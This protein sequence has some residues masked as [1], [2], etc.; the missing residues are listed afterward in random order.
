M[1]NQTNQTS[2]N[3]EFQQDA[4][5]RLPSSSLD[6]PSLG[7]VL[8]AISTGGSVNDSIHSPA[9]AHGK[10]TTSA[11]GDG[12]DRAVDVNVSSGQTPEV[13]PKT[14]RG[15]NVQATDSSQATG[16]THPPVLEAV[17]QECSTDSA[18][19]V[20][21]V[22]KGKTKSNKGKCKGTTFVIYPLPLQ[23]QSRAHIASPPPPLSHD[24][25]GPNTLSGAHS[26]SD[27]GASDDEEQHG[28]QEYESAVEEEALQEMFR[29]RFEHDN[30][31]ES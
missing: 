29:F 3:V 11:S 15:H 6:P 5:S 27:K 1:P 26:D 19:T 28:V 10:D 31:R 2:N 22:V 20:E 16:S 18:D 4:S 21:T 30:A 8:E 13:A 14:K 24:Q 23:S 12:K 25:A 9:P 17:Q 7:Q